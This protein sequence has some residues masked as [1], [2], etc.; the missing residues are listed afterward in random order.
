MDNQYMFIVIMFQL[1]ATFD[2]FG[3]QGGA[4]EWICSYLSDCEEFVYIMENSQ[5][6]YY[7]LKGFP[8]GQS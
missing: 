2:R 4:L 6:N 1:S 5:G 8:K 7:H 3:I